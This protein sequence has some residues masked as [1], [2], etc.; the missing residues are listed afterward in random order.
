MGYRVVG[1]ATTGLDLTQLVSARRFL[2]SS[3]RHGTPLP[4]LIATWCSFVRS[5]GFKNVGPVR[6][7]DGMQRDFSK[8]SFKFKPWSFLRMK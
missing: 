7:G 6:K 2:A 1:V 3:T 4:G 8:Q 5:Q